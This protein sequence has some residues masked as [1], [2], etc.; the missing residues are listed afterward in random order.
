MALIPPPGPSRLL[1]LATFV[2]TL[3]NGLFYTG[4]VLFFT[5]SVGLSPGQVGLGLTL[6]GAAGLLAGI[7]FGHL[8]DRRGAREILVAL[9]VGEGAAVACLALVHSF[10]PFLVVASAYTV[11]D[12]GA[13]GV[14]Q[15]LIAS[16]YAPAERVTGRAYLRSVTNL[17]LALGAAS[18]G[19]A[20]Q[21]DTRAAYVS[22]VLGDAVTFG[23]AAVVLLRLP[24]SVRPTT[25]SVGGMLVALR[26]RPFLAVTVLNGVL[27]MHYVVLEVA[28]PLW[29]TR[30]TDA[31]RWTV[32]LL[33][34]VNTVCC[35]LFQVRAS[36]SS[37]DIPSSA[38]AVRNGSLLIA[39]SCLVFA[40]SAHRSALIAVGVL[41]VAALVNVGGELLQASGSWGLGF[42]LAPEHAQGQYQGLF[43]TGMAAAQMLGPIVITSTAIEHGTAGWVLLAGL[44]LGS[45][46]A[47]RPV[48]AWAERNRPAVLT[49]G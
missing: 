33:Y 49:A 40:A 20:L 29:V 21:L 15:G 7:P 39:A 31:P 35:V 25:P 23:L 28:V 2:N 26:D 22:L 11:L 3:G 36:R 9:M 6:A 34:V 38:L 5:R 43:G 30:A 16:A 24:R 27:S 17:G 45:G 42:G 19:L 32:A 48:S 47:M 44:F 13:N 4:S 10:G 18:A 14:R 12:R 1:A 46:A 8:G 41:V 37:S